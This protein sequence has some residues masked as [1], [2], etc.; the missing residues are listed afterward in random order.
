SP[1]ETCYGYLPNSPLDVCYG[2]GTVV[3]GSSD[4]DKAKRFVQRIQQVH[5]YVREQLEKSQAKYKA[6]HDKHRTDHKF[7]VGD[8]VWLHINKERLAG[9]GRKLKPI[10][11]SPFQLLEKIGNNAFR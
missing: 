3:N 11:Y 1:F 9:E 8:S 4:S 10:Q 6:T 7:K 2:Y 5:Q